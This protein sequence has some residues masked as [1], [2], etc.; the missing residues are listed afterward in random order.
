SMSAVLLRRL[1]RRL[2]DAPRANQSIRPLSSATAAAREDEGSEKQRHHEKQWTSEWASAALGAGLGL[3][4][5]YG[6]CSTRRVHAD[7]QKQPSISPSDPA[8]QVPT[9]ADLPVYKRE[10]VKKHGKGADR[11]WVT[12]KMGVY[13]IT[14]F[15]GDHP[16]GDKILMA[17][18]GAVD[19]FWALYAQHK[20][21]DVMETLETLRIGSLD[22]SEPAPVQTADASDPF[23]TDPER[24]PALKVN[25]AKPFNAESPAALLMDNFRT[26]N[27][28][29]F[30][31]NH[32]P[33]PK[34]D[35]DSHRVRIEGLV[36]IEGV[37]VRKELD[38][39]VGDLK[40][41][42]KEYEITSAVQ[43]SGNRRAEM[44]K[45]KKV[46]GLMWEGYAISNA[47]WTGVRL[48]DV[49]IDLG[50]DPNDEKIRH[51][52]L[53]GADVDPT[54]KPY[55][56]SIPF[57]KAMSPE[58]LIA[59]AMNDE[60]IPRDHGFPLRLIVPG[61]VGARQV[62]W[63]TL[64]RLSGEESPS[65]FQQKDYRV[66]SPAVQHGDELD[67][68]TVP[69]IQDYPIQS[70]FCLPASGTTVDRGTVGERTVGVVLRDGFKIAEDKTVDVAGYAW[71]GGGRGIIRVEVSPDGGKTW[72]SAELEQD[73]D[74]T[75]DKMWAWTLFR[76]SIPIPEG[77][78]A[79]D[80][81]VKATDRSYNTQPESAAG[82][83]NI[84]GLLH[85]AWHH[86]EVKI[87]G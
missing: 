56:A 42:Y 75:Q 68:T 29:F 55:G 48:R 35:L 24:H 45:Y 15:A 17:A 52:H 63:L 3:S 25:N 71:S 47:K 21:A 83:W 80:L 7:A 4:L 73:P 61:V 22:P 70:A 57:E 72:Y 64:I 37:E 34:T 14:D 18:G 54:G 38:L 50:V 58:V 11:L 66:F 69:S 82:I 9:R 84:R 13:D 20:T 6:Y 5:L 27:D 1:A 87:R 76:A 78:S 62:K 2:A 36:H 10:E 85:N 65:H 44:Q 8:F 49:L 26:P 41:K 19:P 33:V 28:L 32:L 81:V 86:V 39:S 77:A 53:E 59:Y 60:D 31:R 79:M 16:G 74:Q 23:S 43:C 30:V 40:K 51:V 46:A 12:Y 67:W